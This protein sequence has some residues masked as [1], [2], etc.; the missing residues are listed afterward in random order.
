MKRPLVRLPGHL[1][2]ELLLCNRNSGFHM[3]AA[4]WRPG[5][6]HQ[7]AAVSDAAQKQQAGTWCM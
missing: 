2:R 1:I 5:T 4:M 7:Q 3:T 6:G